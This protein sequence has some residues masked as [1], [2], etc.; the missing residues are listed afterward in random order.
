VF[1][2]IDIFGAR[3]AAESVE[4]VEENVPQPLK[5]QKQKRFRHG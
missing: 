5:R 2:F 1:Y 4:G 3:Q